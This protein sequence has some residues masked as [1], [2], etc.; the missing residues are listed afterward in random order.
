[1]QGRLKKNLN[2]SRPSEYPSQGGMSKRL[3]SESIVG[4]KDK[5]SSWHLIGFPNGSNIG[6]TVLCRGEAHRYTCCCF[7]H[8]YRSGLNHTQY[9]TWLPIRYVV[10]W[11][12][13][14]QRNIYQAPNESKRKT[15]T[16]KND[17][18]KRTRV[19][20]YTCQKK[21]DRRRAFDRESLV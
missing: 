20:K 9:Y 4:C 8:I 2:V 13:R 17:K 7:L 18:D 3:G 11:T 15:Q 16:N 10:C 1:M 5:F 19:T 12:E 14:D 21:I 6:S